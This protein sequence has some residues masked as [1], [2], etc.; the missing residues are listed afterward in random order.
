MFSMHNTKTYLAGLGVAAISTLAIA[1]APAA[2]AQS[3]YGDRDDG[4]YTS[5]GVTVYARPYERDAATGANIDVVR[6][7]RVVDTRDLDLSTNWGL[8]TLRIRVDR[9]A[10]DACEQLDRHYEG[11]LLDDNNASCISRAAD[12]AMG[13]VQDALYDQTR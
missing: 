4:A 10:S 9:A 8:H 12:R 2:Q 3:Y 13:D 7:S 11:A 6:A 1:A 5:S